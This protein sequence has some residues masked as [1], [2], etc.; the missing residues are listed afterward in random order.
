MS[1]QLALELGSSWL[2]GARR[3][4]APS[5]AQP[6]L[7][8]RDANSLK[9]LAL[10][11]Q[12]AQLRGG[13][14][15]ALQL[16]RPVRAGR[17]LDWPG[18]RSLLQL[19]LGQLHRKRSKPKVALV[20]PAQLTL[21]QQR[22]WKQLALESGAAEA[23]LVDAPL[24][25][26]A[27]CGCDVSRPLGRIVLDWGGG[28]LDLGLVA[29]RQMLAGESL[30]LGG[31]DLDQAVQR[32][33]RQQ[34]GLL[35]SPGQAEELKISM[36]SALFCGPSGPHMEITGFGAIDGLPQSLGITQ[37]DVQGAI[38]PFLTRLREALLRV[39]AQASPEVSADLLEEGLWCCGGSAQLTGLTD[40]LEQI[41]GL[42]VRPVTA[43]EQAAIRG[44]AEWIR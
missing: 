18:A 16:V 20:V 26:A 19:A 5:F 35:L 30:A 33:V 31:L 12:A 34:Q 15:S 21:V 11:D 9:E 2:R 27:G 39:L 1:V 36:L 32:W 42:R 28:S 24:C 41:S 37:Q 38:E 6:S 14:P 7:V 3:G 4:E 8:A 29:G 22:A 43:P 44:L 23:E 25:A 10:G 13:A 40:F 17:I